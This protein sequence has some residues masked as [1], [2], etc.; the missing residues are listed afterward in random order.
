MENDNRSLE[1]LRQELETWKTKYLDIQKRLKE[2]ESSF[3][4]ALDA[5][6]DPIIFYD[7]E[8]KVVYLNPAFTTVFGWDLDDLRNRQIDFVPAENIQETKDAVERM[9]K[10]EKILS[11]ETKRYTKSGEVLDIQLSSSTYKGF[12][13]NPIGSMVIY[14]DVTPRK[15]TEEMLVE[16]E[17]RYRSAMEASADP[18]IVYD[19]EGKVIYFNPAFSRIFKW[20][21][22]E[23]LH[24]KMDDFVPEQNWPE[25]KMMIEKVIAGEFFSG[26]ESAR[27][28]KFGNLIHVSISGSTYKNK[29]N[30]IIGSVISLQDITEKKQTQEILIQSEKMASVGGLA[31]GMAHEL[32]NP[33]ACMMQT[34]DLIYNRLVNTEL[35]ANQNAAQTFGLDMENIKSFMENRSILRM[36]TGIKESGQRAAEIVSNMLSFA[37]KSSANSSSYHPAELIDRSLELAETDYDL[38]K[39]YGFKMIAINK[40]YQENLP[41]VPCIGDKIQQ[42][43]LNILMNGAQAMQEAS[44]ENPA[45]I[46]R[47]RHEK[48][49]NMLS[50]E[51]TDTGP[52]MD[53]DT[54]KRVFEPF[55]TTRQVGV[56][57]GLGLSVAYF[58]VTENHGGQMDVISEPGKGTT[59]IIRLPYT[60]QEKQILC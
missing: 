57:T 30:E 33:L 40:D 6:P 20:S 58:I 3:V 44:T 54:R 52:G 59:F 37:S 8:G 47:T 1:Q 14:R 60:S 26:V 13:G 17:E 39:Q 34:T 24:K 56:G 45:F 19:N 7:L 41:T 18:I 25:T 38:K 32:N 29:D 12:D 27:Y 15:R 42:V 23:R 48:E 10:G 35:T 9:L 43:L 21:L 36:L 16:S 2:N 49:R 51:I 22:E 53:E 4:P 5:V 31:A 46:V 50:I 55:F 11:L 28:D